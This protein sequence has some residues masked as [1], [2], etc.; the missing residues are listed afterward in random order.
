MSRNVL[1]CAVP[2][3]PEQV[4][5]D[6]RKVFEDTKTKREQSNVVEVDAETVADKDKRRGEQC[7]GEK[8]R[9]E[10]VLVE[11]FRD[12]RAQSA[13]RSVKRSDK[14]DGEQLCIGERDH[15]GA[16]IADEEPDEDADQNDVDHFIPPSSLLSHVHRSD[17]HSR[18]REECKRR[19]SP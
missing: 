18:D 9:D 13:E 14:R 19:R 6:D 12:R 4:A 10:D 3:V 7:V 15:N 16:H 11:P 17:E 5:A 8:A 2:I 1:L